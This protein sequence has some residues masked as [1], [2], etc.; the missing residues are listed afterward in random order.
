ME[1]G[2]KRKKLSAMEALSFFCVEKRIV[3][4]R[5]SSWAGCGLLYYFYIL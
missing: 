4:F 3:F 1:K 5:I 2:M